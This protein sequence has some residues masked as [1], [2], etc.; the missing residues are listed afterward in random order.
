M[1]ATEK[2]SEATFSDANCIFGN[3]TRFELIRLSMKEELGVSEMAK[4]L[5]TERSIICYHLGRLESH[6]LIKGRYITRMTRKDRG[7]AKRV[8]GG[9]VKVVQVLANIG[10][11]VGELMEEIRSQRG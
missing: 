6:G 2:F 11:I 3:S 9:T 8:Y 4:A 7:V 10:A 1:K 5:N